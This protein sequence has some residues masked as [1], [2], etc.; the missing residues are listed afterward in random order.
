MFLAPT[1]PLQFPNPIAI[2]ISPNI[3]ESDSVS[4]P[5]HPL[6][7][8]LF[9]S[10]MRIPKKPASFCLALFS[11]DLSTSPSS[12]SPPFRFTSAILRKSDRSH[13]PGKRKGIHTVGSCFLFLSGIVLS[14]TS[15]VTDKC[16][17]EVWL[18]SWLIVVFCFLVVDV[19][20][21]GS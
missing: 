7:K 21:F 17:F 5:P 20:L 9:K 15:C 16:E 2:G 12:L 8:C 6:P 14:W 13:S 3:P 18:S 10:I 4:L 1:L 11:P 19:K